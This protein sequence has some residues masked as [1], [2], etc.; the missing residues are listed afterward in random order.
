MRIGDVE[1]DC[2]EADGD[3][4]GDGEEIDIESREENDICGE[5]V[6]TAGRYAGDDVGT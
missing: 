6:E 4:G 5:H 3:V 2:S 1:D